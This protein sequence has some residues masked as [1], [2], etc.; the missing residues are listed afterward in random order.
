MPGVAGQCGNTDMTS[1]SQGNSY[2]SAVSMLGLICVV[3]LVISG[4][5]V[6]G[7]FVLFAVAMSNYGS[8]K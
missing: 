7:Y 1:P 5:A 3:L 2:R 8:N 4:L 6:V